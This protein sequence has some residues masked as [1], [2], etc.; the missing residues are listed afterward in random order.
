[1]STDGGDCGVN[2]QKKKRVKSETWSQDGVIGVTTRSLNDY[3]G[4]GTPE[5]C[6]KETNYTRRGTVEIKR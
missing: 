2:V 6:K 3:S 1:M 4:G 5:T